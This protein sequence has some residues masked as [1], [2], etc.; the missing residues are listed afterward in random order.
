MRRS[1]TAAGVTERSDAVAV[2]PAAPKY[3]LGTGYGPYSIAMEAAYAT[4]YQAA[5]REGYPAG[6]CR[7]SAGPAPMEI[8]NGYYQVLLEI[9]CTPP[10]APGSGRIVGVQSG[11]CVDV[12]GAGTKEGTPIQ[13]YDCNGTNA[14][15]WRLYSD[16]TVRALGMCMD[17]QFA[18][19]ANGT[20]IG[21][22]RCHGAGNQ[23][24]E[25]LSNGLLRSTFSGKCLA[26]QGH[27]TGNGTRLVLWD[28]TPS[29]TSQQWTGPGLSG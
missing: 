13:L 11:K 10:P 6:N 1:G 17:V 2:A 18:H 27:G 29:H 23:L 21:L 8:G 15:S 22:N 12:Q 16:G 5:A 24:W 3:F 26:A 4:A 9:Y 19:T 20:R 28:C 7:P 25:K 14:Q